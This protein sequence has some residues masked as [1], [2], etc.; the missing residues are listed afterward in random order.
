V[1]IRV[2]VQGEIIAEAEARKP[3]LRA[4][5][6]ADQVSVVFFDEH[7]QPDSRPLFLSGAIERL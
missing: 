7:A 3:A 6:P 2:Y 5:G 4:L 1:K